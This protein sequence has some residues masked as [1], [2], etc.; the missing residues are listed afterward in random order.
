METDIA[1]STQNSN[2]VQVEITGNQIKLYPNP[3]SSVLTVAGV[4]TNAPYRLINISGTTV[5]HGTISNNGQISVSSIAPGTY[6]LQITINN[7][8]QTYKVQVQH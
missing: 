2:T 1:G 8:V 4:T 5:Q 6:L 3:A 7:V